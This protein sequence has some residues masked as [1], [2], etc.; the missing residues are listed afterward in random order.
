MKNILIIALAILMAGCAKDPCK[1]LDC[2]NGG[3]CDN[4]TCLCPEGYEG[5]NCETKKETPQESNFDATKG[6]TL[7]QTVR[8]DG[9]MFDINGRSTVGYYDMDYKN[10]NLRV[11]YYQG[12]Q[13][14]QDFL[15]S[16][17]RVDEFSSD[18]TIISRDSIT[19]LLS[20]QQETPFNKY[21][22]LRNGK[23]SLLKWGDGAANGVHWQVY[24]DGTLKAQTTQLWGEQI[25][26]VTSNTDENAFTC[27]LYNRSDAVLAHFYVNHYNNT[28]WKTYPY[29]SI[30]N[31]QSIIVGADVINNNTYAFLATHLAT[32]STTITVFRFDE[33][34]NSWISE[35][36]ETF[37]GRNLG[38]NLGGRDYGENRYFFSNNGSPIVLLKSENTFFAYK[39]NIPG[40]SIVKEGTASI[41]ASS[42]SVPTYGGIVC[43]QGEIYIGYNTID[44]GTLSA[45][46][47]VRLSGNSFVNVGLPGLTKK[48]SGISLSVKNNKLHAVTYSH[49]FDKY[50]EIYISTPQ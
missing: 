18:K 1:G 35:F 40:R 23:P 24:E 38:F 49:V 48:S 39:I 33:A 8:Y 12:L 45:P 46:S 32:D 43:F 2:L 34:Q 29:G 3:T 31:N 42:A 14:Q 4:G 44:N 11:F 16:T 28:G 36:D 9:T 20:F 37:A 17:T 27:G 15:Y 21:Y 25:G 26:F 10:N 50:G 41:P 22:S 5:V 19:W 13:S 47:V 7:L 30:S 6:W